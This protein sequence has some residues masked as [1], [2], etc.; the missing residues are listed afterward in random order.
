MFIIY[1]TIFHTSNLFNFPFIYRRVNW[2][3]KGM[4]NDWFTF[5]FTLAELKGLRKIQVEFISDLIEHI[6]T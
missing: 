1:I 5:D 6:K 4:I 3:D 2:N